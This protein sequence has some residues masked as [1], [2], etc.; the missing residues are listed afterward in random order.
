VIEFARRA[1]AVGAVDS[2][3]TPQFAEV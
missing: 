3:V 2:G 1:A